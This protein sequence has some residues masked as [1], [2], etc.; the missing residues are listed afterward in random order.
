MTTKEIL[1]VH[2][3][4][5]IRWAVPMVFAAG[6]GWVLVKSIPALQE[7]VQSHDTRIAVLESVAEGIKSDTGEIKEVLRGMS[8]RR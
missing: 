3:G 6:M 5:W 2:G 8:R 7:K 4:E 1:E